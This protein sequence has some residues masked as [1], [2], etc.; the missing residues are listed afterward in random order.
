MN[1]RLL[2]FSIELACAFL[3]LPPAPYHAPLATVGA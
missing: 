1:S 3:F 2:Q